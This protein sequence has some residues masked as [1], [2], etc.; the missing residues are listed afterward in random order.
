MKVI[1]EKPTTIRSSHSFCAGC[2]HGIFYRLIQECVQELGYSDRQIIALGVGC[3][4]N[5]SPIH[6]A[7]KLQAPHGR[8]AAVATGMKRVRP[9]LLIMTYQGDGDAGVIGL[10]ETLNAAYRNEC[11]TVFTVNNCNFG[12]TGGQM[13]WTTMPGQKTATSIHGRDCAAT[14]YPMHLPEMIA[15]S[16]RPAYAARCSVHNAASVAQAKRFV[17]NA[18]E[19]Q[20]NNEGYS[21]VELLAVCPTNWG[22][23]PLKAVEHLTGEIINEYPIAEFKTRD[24]GERL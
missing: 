24:C 1:R 14:G 20:I 23:S 7:D 21:I 10:G 12:M 22:M 13:S 16:F 11:I 3:S 19:A 17:K 4:C 18:L 8:A 9:D 6:D 2:G 15:E 5:I